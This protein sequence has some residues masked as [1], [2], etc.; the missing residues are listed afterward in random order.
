M[1]VVD[2]VYGLFC[3]RHGAAAPGD[4]MAKD[5]YA[6]LS[7]LGVQVSWVTII[8]ACSTSSAGGGAAKPRARA[9][10]QHMCM[11]AHMIVLFLSFFLLQ[12]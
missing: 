9:T 6:V 4:A 1:N 11:H 12:T 8:G 3:C 2:C 5:L 10:G 7:H